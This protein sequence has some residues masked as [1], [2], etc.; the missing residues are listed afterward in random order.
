MTVF[1][2]CGEKKTMLSDTLYQP[3]MILLLLFA[4]LYMDSVVYRQDDELKQS[5]SINS[6]NPTTAKHRNQWGN[7]VR[8]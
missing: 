4:C 8:H 2:M 3:H 5:H 7:P 1:T 6:S